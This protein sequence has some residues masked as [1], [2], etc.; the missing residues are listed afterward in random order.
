MLGT[1]SGRAGEQ[2]AGQSRCPL[3]P[4]PVS[5]CV[6]LGSSRLLDFTSKLHI[7]MLFYWYNMIID[8]S[9][10][11][12]W[13][14]KRAHELSSFGRPTSTRNVLSRSPPSALSFFSASAFEISKSD[15]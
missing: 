10:F 9:T 11:V 1:S 12:S 14:S 13:T 15:I 3:L 7:H 6:C 2:Y 5:T 8:P 4:V